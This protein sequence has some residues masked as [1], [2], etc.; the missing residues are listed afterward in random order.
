[1]LVQT[2]GTN[3]VFSLVSICFMSFNLVRSEVYMVRS[4]DIN[5]SQET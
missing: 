3:C 2:G 4:Y 5:P 1:M